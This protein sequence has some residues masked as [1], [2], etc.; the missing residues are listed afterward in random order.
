MRNFGIFCMVVLL[1]Y[2]GWMLF[3]N[4]SPCEIK[5]KLG[6]TY[7]HEIRGAACYSTLPPFSYYVPGYKTIFAENRG[8]PLKLPKMIGSE[9]GDIIVL[10]DIGSNVIRVD[11][12]GQIKWI[13]NAH[14]VRISSIFRY[15]KKEVG[16]AYNNRIFFLNIETGEKS[17]EL[18]LSGPKILKVRPLEKSTDEFLITRMVDGNESVMVWSEGNY[19][20]IKN[21]PRFSFPRSVAKKGEL[22]VV[23]DTLGHRVVG[24]NLSTHKIEFEIPTY[25]PNDVEFVGE[26]SILIAEEHS[27]R[28]FIYDFRSN[29]RILLIACKL[30]QDF[31]VSIDSLISLEKKGVFLASPGNPKNSKSVC[32]VEFS[33]R[34]T[35]YS[36][37]GA[38]R[39]C[40]GSYLVSDTDNGRVVHLSRD[41]KIIRELL[42]LNNPQSAIIVF[43]KDSPCK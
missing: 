33:G 24:W 1:G 12:N 19:R 2:A 15:G 7:Y 20:P 27:N 35:L 21:T 37:N 23:A 17:R 13:F 5:T 25:F 16:F 29:D 9:K 38:T 18:K 3:L 6:A 34:S 14:P 10:S 36:P 26:S 41:G 40:D 30:F 39:N 32:A 43:D 11:P 42:N 31:T 8:I 22:I 4:F 28:V